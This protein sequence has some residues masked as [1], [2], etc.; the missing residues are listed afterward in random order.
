MMKFFGK[1]LHFFSK[2]V[3]RDATTTD[4]GYVSN[5]NRIE[6]IRESRS[7]NYSTY[8]LLEQS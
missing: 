1:N 2:L 8:A 3:L 6:L 7:N 4:E 5:E